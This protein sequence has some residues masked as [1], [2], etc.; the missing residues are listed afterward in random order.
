M[1]AILIIGG[2]LLYLSIGVFLDEI[3][4]EE[5]DMWSMFY[6]L[7]WPIPIIF[8]VILAVVVYYPTRLAKIFKKRWIKDGTGDCGD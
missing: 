8:I 6:M 2:V 3:L 5:R 1:N 7:C 4:R